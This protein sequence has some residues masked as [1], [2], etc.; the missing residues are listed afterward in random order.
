MKKI[1]L[2]YFW[3]A[4]ICPLILVG[5]TDTLLSIPEIKVTTTKIRN[6]PIGTLS[7]T[8]NASNTATLLA[9][10]VAEL[11]NN[12][13]SIF[14]KNYGAGSLST[15]S[16]RGGSAGHTLVLWN[17]L[18]IQ[19]P[20]LGVLDLS[21]L[22]MNSSEEIILQKGGNT[23]LWGSGAI[24]GVIALNNLPDFNNNTFTSSSIQIGSFGNTAQRFKIGLGNEQ[25]QFVTKVSHQEAKNDFDYFVASNLP[26]RTQTNARFSQQNI[27]QDVYWKINKN[28]TLT[29]HFWQQFST[30]QIPPHL[31]QN[32]SEAHQKDQSTRAILDWQQTRNAL[33][34]QGKL[35]FFKEN[36]N[37]FDDASGL[38][39]NNRFTTFTGEINGQL[40]WKNKH[41]FFVAASHFYTQAKSDGYEGAPTENKTALLFSYRLQQYNYKIQTSIREEYVDGRLVPFVPNVGVDYQLFPWLKIQSKVSKNYR[42]PTLNDRFWRGAGNENLLPESGWSEELTL[43]THWKNK[44]YTCVFSV[45]GFN[46][47]IKNWILWSP[48]GGSFFWSP[49][50][51][52]KVWSRGLEPHFAFTFF[53]KKINIKL[54]TGLD[55][56]LSTNQIAITI[57]RIAEGSQLYYTPE[58]QGFAN[59][60]LEWKRFY[61]FYQHQFTGEVKGFNK[62]LPSYHV[63]NIRIQYF[64]KK[65]KCK[66]IV[67]AKINNIWNKDYRVIERR[68]MPP[69]HYQFGINFIFHKS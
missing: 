48:K 62:M 12:E 37:Y 52:A 36:Q 28:N 63:G 8:W 15:S 50:N 9:S 30:Q 34:L 66:T 46:R 32:K 6:H 57:P 35:G 53:T 65:T 18:P 69:I 43:T 59:I 20:M 55:Y 14:I 23:A 22:P 13:S 58:I 17:G 56:I 45:T 10:N 16:I 54:D 21:L 1:S 27:L 25:V 68:A 33:I 61:F 24:G 19:S 47:N 67:F 60:N 39:T 4:W 29:S 2:F 38:K 44:N 11:L 31:A 26:R 7:K 3:I 40:F 49:D 64:T 51:I 41:Q 5:Q 42:L